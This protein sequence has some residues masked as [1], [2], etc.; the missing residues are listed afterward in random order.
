M[1]A[2]KKIRC[3]KARGVFQVN[4]CWVLKRMLGNVFKSILVLPPERS[5][6]ETEFSGVAVGALCC[7]FYLLLFFVHVCV[8]FGVFLTRINLIISVPGNFC[9]GFDCK[10]WVSGRLIC[11]F[12][13]HLDC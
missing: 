1:T 12:G 7:F 6:I 9:P 3:I 8:C 10:S 13:L 11:P 2:C 4:A 5:L